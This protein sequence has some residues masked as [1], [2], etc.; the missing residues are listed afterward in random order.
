MFISS[1]SK[2]KYFS[3]FSSPKLLQS[4]RRQG[5]IDLKN[6]QCE[7]KSEICCK[8][9]D[10]RYEIFSKNEKNSLY[11]NILQMDPGGAGY[12]Y[13]VLGHNQY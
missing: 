12:F 5:D 8:T 1:I 4:F 10:Y 9:P 2:R 3:I 13:N 6:L 7:R 11:I